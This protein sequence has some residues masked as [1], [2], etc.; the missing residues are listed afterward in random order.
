MLKLNFALLNSQKSFLCGRIK[1]RTLEILRKHSGVY[2]IFFLY[3]WILCTGKVANL[4][5]CACGNTAD[6]Y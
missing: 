4:D 2:L 6:G 5:R 1:A 3:K